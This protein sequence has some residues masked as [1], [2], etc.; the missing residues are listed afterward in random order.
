MPVYSYVDA[1]GH[2][3]QIAH[4]M[5]DDPVVTC[6]VCNARMRRLYFAPRVNWAGFR[7]EMGAAQK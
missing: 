7:L 6:S 1:Q 2:V 4:P 5:Q 3:T